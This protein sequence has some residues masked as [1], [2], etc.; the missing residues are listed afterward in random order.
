M[1]LALL[2]GLIN[3]NVGG[4][5]LV[6]P[7]APPRPLP[8]ARC[9]ISYPKSNAPCVF[10]AACPKI[11]RPVASMR[12]A[13]IVPKSTPRVSRSL[14]STGYGWS[15]FRSTPAWRTWSA[16]STTAWPSMNASACTVASSP[17]QTATCSILTRLTC[18]RTISSMPYWMPPRR[19]ATPSGADRWQP[20]TAPVLF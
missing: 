1:K 4:I 14:P 19:V 3:A 5:L 6:G 7:R 20:P 16:A 13:R 15:R 17:N 8:F 2:L 12:F 18:S 10:M 11:S 9:W